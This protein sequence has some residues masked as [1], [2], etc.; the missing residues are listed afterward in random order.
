VAI[1]AIATSCTTSGRPVAHRPS[2]S[3]TPPLLLGTPSSTPSVSRSVGGSIQPCPKLANE[4]IPPSRVSSITADGRYVSFDSRMRLEPRDQGGNTD[5]Y[6]ADL[7][8][9][10]VSLVSVAV[11]GRSGNGKSSDGDLS[12]DQTRVAFLSDASDLVRHDVNGQTD[13]FVRDRRRH[14]TMIASVSES[15]RQANAGVEEIVI[16][17][18]GRYVAFTSRATN[19]TT[20]L[21]PRCSSDAS[22]RACAN[23]FVRDLLKEKTELVS[24]GVAGGGGS[25]DSGSHIGISSDGRF[26]SF[27]SVAPDL[28][29]NDAN[30][31][32]D[33][34]IR[35]R[36][37]SRT[38]VA[39]VSSSGARADGPSWGA[40]LSGDGSLITF[41]S[42][43]RNLATNA[44]RA[45]QIYLREFT[46][47]RTRLVSRDRAEDAGNAMSI[48]SV[49][50]E[51]GRYVAFAFYGSNLPGAP[52]GCGEGGTA[53]CPNTFIYDRSHGS[54]RII[55]EGRPNGPSAVSSIRP[56]V[57]LGSIEGS[58][59]LVV[60]VVTGRSWGF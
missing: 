55:A 6:V 14:T 23:V 8:S 16:S 27:D 41:W 58:Q 30:G 54:L 31:V 52:A 47:G 25:G 33:V 48:H 9:E 43:A 12:D 38:R 59:G 4:P 28:V 60:D 46:T 21:S 10:C 22:P 20:G 26:V 53:Q 50:S 5:V 34:F 15:G 37:T 57:C 11:S 51:N 44:G 40:S 35:D 24:V 36:M 13:A 39:S 7:S 19:L 3:P 56:R 45:S 18:N 32:S 1:A 17:G 2:Q 42:T 29:T 49:L